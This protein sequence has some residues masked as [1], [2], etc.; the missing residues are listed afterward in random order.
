MENKYKI[1]A[2]VENEMIADE[3]IELLEN[4]DIKAFKEYEG[5]SMSTQIYMNKPLEGID[6]EVLE[7]DYQEAKDLINAFFSEVDES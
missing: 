5:E 2:N 6:L 7:E 3:I 1:L 4:N